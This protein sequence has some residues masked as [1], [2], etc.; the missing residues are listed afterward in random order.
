MRPALNERILNMLLL[1][2][3]GLGATKLSTRLRPRVSQPTLWRALDLLRAQGAIIREG[4]ARSTRNHARERTDLAVLRSRRMHE[5]V[6]KRLLREPALRVQALERLG[7]LRAAN[8]HGRRYHDRCYAL[9][10]GPLA[11][12]LRKE[13]PM[14]AFISPAERHQFFRIRRKGC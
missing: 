5:S 11:D 9:L 2:G 8:R 14:V 12:L 4:K 7:K 3:D 10:Q 1:H 6:A 13:S